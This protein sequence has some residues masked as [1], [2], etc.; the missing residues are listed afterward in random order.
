MWSKENINVLF[1]KYL[2]ETVGAESLFMKYIRSG[3][4]HLNIEAY[5]DRSKVTISIPSWAN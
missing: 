4:W 1:G 3:K 5:I 2:I